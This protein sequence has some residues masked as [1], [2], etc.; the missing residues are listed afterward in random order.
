MIES[1]WKIKLTLL[2]IG[3]ALVGCTRKSETLA[4]TTVEHGKGPQG[5]KRIFV[6]VKGD[7][8]L[9]SRMR[10][11]LDFA[12]ED[13]N[14]A[15]VD[16]QSDSDAVLGVEITREAGTDALWLGVIHLHFRTDG[17]DTDRQRCASLG[18]SE[19]GDLFNLSSEGIARD[20]R[21]NFPNARTV[22]FDEHSDMTKSE[23][24]RSE[25][26]DALKT[27]GFS[28]LNGSSPDVVLGVDL[29]TERVP[30]EKQTLKYHISFA[31]SDEADPYTM[32][33]YHI[34]SAKLKS[35]APEVCPDRFNDLDWLAGSSDPISQVAY[36]LAKNLNKRNLQKREP[37]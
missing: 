9:S 25:L 10:T 7:P 11:Y 3:S 2:L 30:I 27:S 29:T 17:K 6:Q 5:V 14:F 19:A 33:G 35:N 28:V 1:N 37:H 18:N 31:G 34:L 24:F 15:V 16:A 8:K 36:E 20:I 22:K 23:H 4:P 13:R 26:E 32:D 21:D 12:L